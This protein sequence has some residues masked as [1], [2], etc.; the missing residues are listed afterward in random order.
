MT[1]DDFTAH[2][3]QFLGLP[4]IWGADG[5]DAFDCSG[6]AQKL[7]AYVGL[8][9][10]GDQTAK[11]LYLY[12]KDNGRS[13]AVP[14][15]G[16]I[17][18]TLAF[19]GKPTRVGHVAICL[20]TV[21]MI[22]AGKGGPDTT[23]VEKA[24]AR[25]AEVMISP[26]NRRSDIVAFLTPT[27]LPWATVAPPG[28]FERPFSAELSATF[29]PP[30]AAFAPAAAA[31]PIPPTP[32]NTAI[33]LM[34]PFILEAAAYFR[35]DPYVVVGIGSRESGWGTSPLLRPPGPTGTGDRARR[36][37][38]PPLRPGPLPPDGLGFGR[39]LMQIDWD[40]HDFA[41]TGPWQ[42]PKQNIAYA[43]RVLRDSIAFMAGRLPGWPA[44]D[45][46]QCGIAGYN[47]GPGRVLDAVRRGGMAAV[48]KPTAHGDYS[49]DV[50]TR[51]RAF[52]A[53][54]ILA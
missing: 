35:L 27:G 46:Q 11:D 33:R 45:I 49:A 42:D 18:G 52:Q 22:E 34:R 6:L 53:M 38:N 54:S 44:A 28:A 13:R 25:H 21:Y 29:A 19:F 1:P 47:A 37:P 17:C 15:T 9:P 20:D 24:R 10:P 41:R 2:A 3:K 43:C 14:Q 23:T 26:I 30:A 12:F 16:A 40:A 8:D 50:L 7:L 48:D 39:G 51:A 5:P 32:E 4:Y 31:P 36:R